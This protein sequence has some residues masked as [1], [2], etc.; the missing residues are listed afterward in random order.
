MY[1][2]LRSWF[3]WNDLTK[4]SRKLRKKR[5]VQLVKKLPKLDEK[6]RRKTRYL[7]D[8]K[9]P[10]LNKKT[11]KKTYLQ[12]VKNLRN[13]TRKIERKTKCWLRIRTRDYWRLWIKNLIMT[14]TSGVT[15]DTATRL[16]PRK[17]SL[18]SV[19]YLVSFI[20]SFAWIVKLLF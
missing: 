1:K 8:E 12:G 6:M 16:G 11:R 2:R 17:A 20:S 15:K 13:L 7:I 19:Q 10:K 9:L 4:P 18:L 5:Y 14:S 3:W